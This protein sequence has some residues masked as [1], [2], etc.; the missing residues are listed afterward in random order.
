MPNS[1]RRVTLQEGSVDSRLS[2]DGR[3]PVAEFDNHALVGGASELLVFRLD[4]GHERF[5]ALCYLEVTARQKQC[6][7]VSISHHVVLRLA[8]HVELRRYRSNAAVPRSRGIGLLNRLRANLRDEV[9]DTQPSDRTRSTANDGHHAVEHR[10][11][12]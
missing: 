12:R 8:M 2:L 5:D 7:G 3:V 9:E 10:G 6:A 11:G 4:H 1:P